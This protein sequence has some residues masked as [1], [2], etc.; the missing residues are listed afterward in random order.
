MVTRDDKSLINGELSDMELL[1]KIMMKVITAEENWNDKRFS[2][3]DEAEYAIIPI[4]ENLYERLI[5]T[6]KYVEKLDYEEA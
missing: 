5:K 1:T 2:L 6:Q 4:I 3:K